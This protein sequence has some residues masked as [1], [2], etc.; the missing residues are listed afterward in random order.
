MIATNP[1]YIDQNLFSESIDSGDRK[2]AL[3]LVSRF[4][5]HSTRH[6][7]ALHA[8]ME[9]DDID[10]LRKILHS[11]NSCARAV[12]AAALNEMTT[13]LLAV[14]TNALMDVSRRAFGAYHMCFKHTIE[15]LVE[16]AQRYSGD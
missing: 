9:S 12:G 8:A 4:Y 10:E 11:V 6:L 13:D 3:Q 14:N 5:I 1:P 2:R 15:A 7:Q 16:E